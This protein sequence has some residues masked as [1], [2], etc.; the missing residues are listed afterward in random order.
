[1]THAHK[2][3]DDRSPYYREQLFS[4]G[5]CGALGLVAVLLYFQKTLNDQRV[6]SLLLANYLHPFLVGSGIALLAIVALRGFFLWLSVRRQPA[7]HRQD[8]EDRKSCCQLHDQDHD[9][10]WGPLRYVL[11]SMPVMLFLL[12]L[13]NEGFR[14]ARGVEIEELEREIT[15]KQGDVVNLEFME[16]YNSVYNEAKREYLQGRTGMLKGQLAR[17]NSP[18]VLTLIR[19]KKGCCAADA[20]PLPVAVMSPE[21]PV[22]IDN[23]AWVEVTGQIQYVKRKGQDQTIPVLKLRSRKDIIPT[24]S[25]NPFFLE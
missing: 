20:I 23:M 22:G 11:L 7:S 1:M 3:A 8:F 13:P 12:G 19:F 2:H 15:E 25:E 9:H 6:L 5:A 4:M 24:T 10:A 21:G 14:C 18:T 17:G 16:F